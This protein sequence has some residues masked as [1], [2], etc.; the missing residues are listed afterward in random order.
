MLPWTRRQRRPMTNPTTRPG[1]TPAIRILSNL[2]G[3]GR[4]QPSGLSLEFHSWPRKHWVWASVLVFLKSFRLDYILLN[5]SP[6]ELLILTSLKVLVPFNRCRIVVLDILLSRPRTLRDRLKAA[7]RAFLLRRCHRI[8]LYYKDTQEIR[9]HFSVPADKIDFV[10]FK[11]N[12]FDIV[13]STAPADAGYIFCGGKTRR[14]FATLIEAVRTLP[15]PVKI[16]T[17]A[18]EDIARHGSWLD[19]TQELPPNVEVH[20]LPGGPRPFIELMAAS[21]LMV[22]PIKPDITGV[23]IGVYIMA[24][25]LGKCV[26]IS[27][28]PSTEG[29]LTDDLAVLVPPEDPAALRAGIE[30]AYT[31]EQLRRR[32]SEN[33]RRYALALGGEENLF[34]TVVDWLCNDLR[35]SK[36]QGMAR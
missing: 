19:E 4:Q 35:A 16:A 29:I 13:T 12:E 27:T 6:R 20:R 31:D 2:S 21:R 30:R 36:Q 18:N 17:T 34:K 24:M 33:G 25:A 5:G 22:L 26:V 32:L 1:A 7:L 23:G 11:I 28:G 9:R 8:L 14:D 3:L 15:Y 10:P